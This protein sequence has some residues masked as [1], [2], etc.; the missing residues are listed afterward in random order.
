MNKYLAITKNNVLTQSQTILS[1][2]YSSLFL[3]NTGIDD[4]IVND[5][6]LIVPGSSFS[7]DN[8]PYVVIDENTSIHF[9]NNDVNQKLLV[10]KTYF[11]EV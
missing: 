8:L 3:K 9:A 7:F 2:G 4:V 5:N 11:K 10:I 1:D 6:I